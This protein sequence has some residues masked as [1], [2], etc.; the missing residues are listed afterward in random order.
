MIYAVYFIQQLESFMIGIEGEKFV[1]H[2]K[3]LLISL[4]LLQLCLL[5][6]EHLLPVPLFPIPNERET[7]STSVARMASCWCVCSPE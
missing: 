3:T 1:I 4:P 2:P 6:P 7:V 5:L